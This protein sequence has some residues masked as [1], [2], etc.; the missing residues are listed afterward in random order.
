MGL[1]FLGGDA[2]SLR[3]AFNGD[4]GETRILL[5]TS[6]TCE[7]CRQGA[8]VIQ[9]A[10]LDRISDP[11]L[12]AYVVWVPILPDDN[13]PAARGAGGLVTD[14]GATHF[15]DEQRVLPDA[16]A[17]T[18]KLPPDLPAWDIYMAY[19][20][21]VVWDAAPPQPTFWY[22]QLGDLALAPRLDGKA[23]AADVERIM[24]LA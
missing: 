17:A 11:S 22:H 10:V 1:T 3:K 21:G 4:A 9:T 18:L 5:L 8:S 7:M 20:P 12:R 16:F 13:E 24:R 2:A 15:W 19:A 23:F 14:A 6:P